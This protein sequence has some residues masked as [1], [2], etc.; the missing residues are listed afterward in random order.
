MIQ[1]LIQLIANTMSI[2]MSLASITISML[3]LW[4][5]YT[6]QRYDI[7]HERILG[8]IHITPQR[9]QQE[10]PEELLINI[11][12]VEPHLKDQLIMHFNIQNLGWSFRYMYNHIVLLSDDMETE[13]MH[14]PDVAIEGESNRNYF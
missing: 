5:A 6:R 9:V 13:I 11:I 4:M 8:E 12:S 14:N 2:L 3:T 7:Q 10:E 1:Q